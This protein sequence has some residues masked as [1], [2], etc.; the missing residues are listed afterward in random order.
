MPVLPGT[1]GSPS[2]PIDLGFGQ[3]ILGIDF[4]GSSSS[5]KSKKNQTKKLLPWYFYV[6][7][8]QPVAWSFRSPTGAGSG[9]WELLPNYPTAQDLE[10]NVNMPIGPPLPKI[11]FDSLEDAI[12]KGTPVS[13]YNR[14]NFF[15][16]FLYKILGLQQPYN[17]YGK[18]TQPTTAFANTIVTTFTAD[19]NATSD[20]YNKSMQA[21]SG[22]SL[23]DGAIPFP[24]TDFALPLLPGGH[25]VPIGEYANYAGKYF[26]GGLP[27]GFWFSQ[28]SMWL[29]QPAYAMSVAIA[30]LDPTQ[31]DMN[32]WPPVERPGGNPGNYGGYASGGYG[33]YGSTSTIS[34]GAGDPS[35]PFTA[36][37]G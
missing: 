11:G 23:S 12:N 10:A 14:F 29:S 27:G 25:G 32:V 24:F 1:P 9:R 4:S 7:T 2:N 15:N 18:P 28:G 34:S 30:Q 22:T 8:Q 21:I 3:F 17:K 33:A 31:W 37:G 5:P 20:G 6:P 19:W 36:I 35:L 13:D 26:S 16:K